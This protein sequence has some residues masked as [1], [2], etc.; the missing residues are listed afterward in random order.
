MTILKRLPFQGEKSDFQTKKELLDFP[1]DKKITNVDSTLLTC[2]SNMFKQH[3]I[4]L[5]ICYSTQKSDI[6]TVVGLENIF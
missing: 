4:P 5:F 2:L 1:K 3:E 6:G